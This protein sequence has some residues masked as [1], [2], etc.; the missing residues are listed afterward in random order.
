[1][2]GPTLPPVGSGASLRPVPALAEGP[3]TNASKLEQLIREIASD[4]P[5]AAARPTTLGGWNVFFL[6]L[7][8]VN[9]T[10][11]IWLIPPES[12]KDERLAFL[13]KV[14]PGVGGSLFVLVTSWYKYSEDVQKKA[15]PDR[16]SQFR[17]ASSS[18]LDANLINPASSGA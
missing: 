3:D 10:L 14:I 5:P 8:V 11:C 13:E 2:L 1:M 9:V 6:V 16:R 15:L 17:C 12:L 4:A 18:R 7:L